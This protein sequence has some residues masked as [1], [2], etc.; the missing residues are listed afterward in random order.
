MKTLK[1][2]SKVPL[3]INASNGHSILQAITAPKLEILD[4]YV[5]FFD[6]SLL[7]FVKKSPRIWKISFWYFNRDINR[8]L[9][10]AMEFLLYCPSLSEL[11][12]QDSDAIRPIP[13]GDEFLRTFVEEG[14]HGVV[15]PRLQKFEFI[16]N[17]KFSI[18][19]LRKLLEGKHGDILIPN[20]FPWRIVFISKFDTRYVS[21]NQQLLDLVARM[22]ARG[23]DVHVCV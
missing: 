5:I 3:S 16:G 19:A 18:G 17:L 23:L 13:G 15:C 9:T 10:E 7:D 6:L 4:L 14:N 1:L 20:V 11:S 22:R 21:K 12:I 2:N 8:S